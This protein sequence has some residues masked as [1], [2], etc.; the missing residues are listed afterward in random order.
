M[1]TIKADAY[2]ANTLEYEVRGKKYDV[3]GDFDLNKKKNR[4]EH[5]HIGKR[6][7]EYLIVW[8]LS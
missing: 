5:I 6:G 8:K 2:W 3:T 7:G 4:I 1:R